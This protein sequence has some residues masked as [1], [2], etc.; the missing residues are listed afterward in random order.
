MRQRRKGFTLVELLVVIGI[1]ALLI[2]VLMPALNSARSAARLVQCQSNLKQIYN[3]VLFYANSNQG[4][5]PYASVAGGWNPAQEVLTT[6]AGTYLELSQLIGYTPTDATKPEATIA[7]VFQCVEGLTP[8]EGTVVWAPNLVRAIRFNV[9]AFPGYDQMTA[10]WSKEY[11]QRKLSSIRNSTEKI[12]F[13]E[14]PQLLDWNLSCEPESIHMD[15]WRYSWGHMFCD[16]SV[17][18]WDQNHLND[19]LDTGPNRDHNGWWVCDVRFRHKNNTMGPFAFF[20][21]HV[22]V[23]RLGE[24]K[25]RE[26]CINRQK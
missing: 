15:G 1:I 3:G 4:F 20:D 14:G 8:D 5:L 26:M 17:A 12:A 10:A 7:P 23:R 19:A 21:G 2:S 18:D 24:I 22:E 6:N 16:P 9:R 25:V 13:W 11:P